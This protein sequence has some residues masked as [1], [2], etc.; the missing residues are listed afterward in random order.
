MPPSD[1]D[2]HGLEATNR[3][4]CALHVCIS[5]RAT[6]CPRE[7]REARTGRQLYE[8]LRATFDESPMRDQVE[9]K[10]AECLSLCPRPCGIVLASPGR[11]TYLFGDQQLQASA[12]DIV[13]CVSLY[14][15]ALNGYMPREERPKT[16]RA[17]ILGRVPPLPRTL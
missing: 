7:P 10:P 12:D 13:A 5:C 3:K 15:Q 17:S 1:R 16:L 8:E 14:L 4:S 6:G 9:V 2:R 11:W